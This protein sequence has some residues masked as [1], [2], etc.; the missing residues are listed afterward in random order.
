MR[1]WPIFAEGKAEVKG[2]FF[3]ATRKFRLTI[4][5]RPAKM[6]PVTSDGQTPMPLSKPSKPSHRRTVDS[7]TAAVL[8][9]LALFEA[10]LIGAAKVALSFLAMSLAL[11]LIGVAS[12]FQG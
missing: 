10:A 8:G 11:V 6:L 2:T 12:L 5:L 4:H 1:S 9:G 7:T 3:F